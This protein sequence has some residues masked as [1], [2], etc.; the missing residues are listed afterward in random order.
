MKSKSAEGDTSKTASDSRTNALRII[1]DEP[2][3]DDAL[4]FRKL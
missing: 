4:D 2:T 3:L 1:T